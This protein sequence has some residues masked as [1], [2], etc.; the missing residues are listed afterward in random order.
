MPAKIPQIA[1]R[2]HSVAQMAL[3]GPRPVALSR[4]ERVRRHWHAGL[5]WRPALEPRH[6][7]RPGDGACPSRIRPRSWRMLRGGG[8]ATT[9]PK[10][11]SRSTAADLSIAHG[12][13]DAILQTRCNFATAEV[14][15]AGALLT[16]KFSLIVWTGP[17]PR[18]PRHNL[19]GKSRASDRSRG[20]RRR[21]A[22]Q[23][24]QEAG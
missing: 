2:V 12:D 3:R 4:L 21:Q 17:G 19:A 11:C 7:C 5:G 15:G 22:G 1:L 6:P 14:K 13:L 18:A 16:P 20:T 8:A 24:G 23:P 10:V 9:R